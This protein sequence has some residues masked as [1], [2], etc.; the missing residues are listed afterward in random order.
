MSSPQK[1]DNGKV[2]RTSTAGRQAAWL[3]VS[4]VLSALAL[5]MVF[6]RHDIHFKE[7]IGRIRET[8]IAVFALMAVSSAVFHIVIGADKMWRVLR[9]MR[10]EI[11]FLE[12]LGIRLASGPLRLLF[13]V[14]SGEVINIIYFHR[15]KRLPVGRAS[16]AVIF[17]R[18]LNI[19]GSFFWLGIGILMAGGMKAEPLVWTGIGISALYV[20]FFFLS[21]IHSALIGIC[22]KIHR[23]FG[24]FIKDTLSPFREFTFGQKAFFVLYGI[25]FQTRPLFVYYVLLLAAGILPE[26]RTFILNSSL[27]LFAG[28]VPSFGGAGPRELAFVEIF[29]QYGADTVLGVGLLMSIVVFAIPTALGIPLIPW[30]VRRLAR[31]KQGTT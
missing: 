18:G 20:A 7:L 16:G 15:H 26:S 25:I 11:S 3:L 29:K 10:V 19:I 27:A 23:G 31:N 14:K 5:W 28:H 2:A 6:R 13:P 24:D 12:T 22:A 9:A 1:D 4:I 30:Y 21:P 8:D 17:D